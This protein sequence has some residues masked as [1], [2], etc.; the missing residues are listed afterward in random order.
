M[1]F[2]R[3][4]TNN[5]EYKHVLSFRRHIYVSPPT[6]PIP[7]TILITHEDT[8]NRIFLTLDNLCFICKQHGH[9]SSSCSVN[10][11]HSETAVPT[12]TLSNRNEPSTVTSTET[13]AITPSTTCTSTIISNNS[14]PLTKILS[15]TNVTPLDTSTTDN[16]MPVISKPNI[17]TS[18]APSSH[19]VITNQPSSSS[20]SN[21]S[22]SV[23]ENKE[24]PA[25]KEFSVSN[26]EN[27]S[28][29]SS[30]RTVSEA[31]S[32]PIETS[33]SDDVFSK[34]T[35]KQKR[36]KTKISTIPLETL[37][38]PIKEL[39]SSEKQILTFEETVDLFENAHGTKDV[40]SV[41][42]K[43][44]VDILGFKKL[45][46]K[47]HSYTSERSLKLKCTKLNK[48]I[49]RQLTKDN[50]EDEEPDTDTSTE[51]SQELNIQ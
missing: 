40:I 17:S 22:C 43:Y 44:T 24:N 14:T 41:V 42:N 38:Q 32:P 31:I 36:I 8:T 35:Q 51:L 7:D 27:T 50:Y 34:P 20:L 21:N 9:I 19:I 12:A 10:V 49:T 47:I 2:L 30:K 46:T 28:K 25:P 4:G 16:T 39:F 29:S 11:N 6:G 48:K 37:M 5:P 45:I 3:I 18:S 26:E 23:N 13:T 15:T 33:A 1:S